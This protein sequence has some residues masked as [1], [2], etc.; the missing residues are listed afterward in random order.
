MNLNDFI[1][2][3]LNLSGFDLVPVRGNLNLSGFELEFVRGNLN[4][5]GFELVWYRCGFIRGNLN[6]GFELV[7]TGT[8]S[9][10]ET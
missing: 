10:E 1:R 8:V 3:N 9:S 5:S 7:W 2:G 4:L 6:S